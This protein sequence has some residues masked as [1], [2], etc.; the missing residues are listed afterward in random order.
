MLDRSPIG[1]RSDSAL[2]EVCVDFNKCDLELGG[3]T[4]DPLDGMNVY[5]KR[6]DGRIVLYYLREAIGQ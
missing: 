2:V 5:L 6:R 4:M 1:L 3:A